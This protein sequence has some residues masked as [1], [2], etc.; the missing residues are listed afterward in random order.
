MPA[1]EEKKGGLCPICD[2]RVELDAKKCPE[3]KADL[4]LFGV[5]T[6]EGEEA[7]DVDITDEESLE[8]LL[9]EIGKKNGKKEHEI[10]EEIMAAVDNSDTIPQKEGAIGTEV[11]ERVGVE[12]G[13]EKEVEKATEGAV[14]FECPLCNTLV[15]EDAKSCSG[16]GAIFASGE[17]EVKTEVAE[18]EGISIPPSETEVIAPGEV[19]QPEEA[20]APIEEE[21]TPEPKKKRFKIG[22]KKKKEEPIAA[23][24]VKPEV[25]GT[26][27]EKALR[28]ELTLCVSEVKPLL[29]GAR[30]YG[31]NVFEGRSLIDQAITAGK[32]RDFESAISLVKDSKKIIEDKIGQHI[33]DN[34][35]GTQ[36]KID[37]VRKA[38]G[39]VTELESKLN[40]VQGLFNEK[41]YIEAVKLAKAAAEDT[42]SAVI[43][44]KSVLKKR[45]TEEEKDVTEK[46]KGLVELI[47][48]GEEVKVN[49]KG[50][51]ALLTQ[52]RMAI[53]K[54][55]Y[56]KAEEYLV[57]AKEDFLK[58]LPKQITDIIANSK[59]MLY[60]AKMQGVDIK[61]SIKLL[62]EASTAL[63][64]NNYLDAL[65]AIKRYRAE[66]KQYMG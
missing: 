29:A 58:E 3:C 61:P 40:E 7:H 46:V 28:K 51:I 53:K 31:I 65:N 11:E 15:N 17:E 21:V 10:F 5:K 33:I 36:L 30:Q 24:S 16:C 2:S 48:S 12:E 54:N 57:K 50:T 39:E 44:L 38:G 14:M 45:E 18:E 42:E 56:D 49:V 9:G 59:P 1:E 41:R 25:V 52:A 55:E 35:Q 43:K 37:A 20:A 6:T 22:K 4:S 19:I 63:K 23:P 13:V 62:K 47:K 27:G 26:S 8:K 60:K 66:M 64:L 32:Q 34:I